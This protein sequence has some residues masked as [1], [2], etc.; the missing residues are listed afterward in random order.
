M[1]LMSSGAPA[2][3]HE[4]THPSCSRTR[5]FDSPHVQSHKRRSVCMYV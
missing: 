4:T 1:G 5:D 2:S 3:V